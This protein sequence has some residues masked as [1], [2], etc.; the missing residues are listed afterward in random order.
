M[1]IA[2]LHYHGQQMRNYKLP[3]ECPHCDGKGYTSAIVVKKRKWWFDKMKYIEC[4]YC[5]GTGKK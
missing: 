4:K 2:L 5:K 1:S 3:P